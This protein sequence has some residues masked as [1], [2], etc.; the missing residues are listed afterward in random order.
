MN[1]YTR[2]TA[3]NAEKLHAPARKTIAMQ[4]ARTSSGGRRR[5]CAGKRNSAVKRKHAS[6]R[7]SAVTRSSAGRR[8][9]DGRRNYAGRMSCKRPI[10]ES[11]NSSSAFRMRRKVAK[12]SSADRSRSLTIAS[13]LKEGT[14]MKFVEKIAKSGNSRNIYDILRTWNQNSISNMKRNAAKGSI[15]S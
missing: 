9:S 7:N 2:A 8:N 12:K 11:G 5:S 14:K 3:A 13:K 10:T 4:D 6:R 15:A 1:A